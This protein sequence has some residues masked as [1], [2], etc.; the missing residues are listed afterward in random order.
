MSFCTQ[1]ATKCLEKEEGGESVQTFAKVTTRF[2]S[3]LGNWS[4]VPSFGTGAPGPVWTRRQL[5]VT[6]GWSKGKV[7]DIERGRTL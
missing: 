6:W 7:L 4:E 2:S 5:E 3:Y 1:E